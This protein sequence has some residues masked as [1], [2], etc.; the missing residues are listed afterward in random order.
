MDPIKAIASIIGGVAP[1]V[2]T[3][4][5]GPLAGA[6]TKLL[7]TG[8]GLA[9]SAPETI[10]GAL[11]K[12]GEAVNKALSATEEDA[13]A[14]WGY[15]TEGVKSDAVQGQ[16]INTTMQA[17]IASGVSWW[18]W[19]HL[20]GYVTLLWLFAP[21][22]FVCAAMYLLIAQGKVDPFNA[23]IGGMAG[24]VAWVAICAGLN[25]YVALDTSRRTS[26]AATGTPVASLLGSV[27]GIFKRR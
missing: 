6:A 17:E 13:K 25:G 23:I 9:D 26:A 24:M 10:L 20:I 21:L 2:A 14:K 1:T 27:V 12:G 18:H 19:R 8:L 15:L 16:S 5:G 7:A 11:E 3:M 22:P 4:L